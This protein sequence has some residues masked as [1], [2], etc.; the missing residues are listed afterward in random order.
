MK[1]A[2]RSL[3]MVR[4]LFIRPREDNRYYVGGGSVAVALGAFFEG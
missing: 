1:V 4:K 2:A 3:L